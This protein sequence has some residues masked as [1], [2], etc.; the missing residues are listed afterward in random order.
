MTRRGLFLFAGATALAA[1]V[2][3]RAMGILAADASVSALPAAIELMGVQDKLRLIAMDAIWVEDLANALIHRAKELSTEVAGTPD[4]LTWLVKNIDPN[5]VWHGVN[6]YFHDFSVERMCGLL[7]S[8]ARSATFWDKPPP[9][10]AQLPGI[11]IDDFGISALSDLVDDVYVT[12]KIWDAFFEA[13]ATADIEESHMYDFATSLESSVNISLEVSGIDPS[14]DVDIRP[15]DD[16]GY[17]G[18][19]E[20]LS[21]LLRGLERNVS[22]REAF[23]QAMVE[24]DDLYQRLLS[25]HARAPIAE[26]TP[27]FQSRTIALKWSYT[28]SRYRDKWRTSVGTLRWL[29]HRFAPDASARAFAP[30]D[31][32][33]FLAATDGLSDEALKS[34]SSELLARLEPLFS[35]VPTIRLPSISSFLPNSLPASTEPDSRLESHASDTVSSEPF[36]LEHRPIVAMPDVSVDVG[37]E[38]SV[39]VR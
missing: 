24:S 12:P 15:A 27:E 17:A 8:L 31:M 36:L 39:E 29:L 37:E 35:E 38:A 33:A 13:L 22:L 11:F 1:S 3:G 16:R 9:G 20:F 18:A 2:P 25:I 14:R 32:R 7:E 21:H 28:M 19:S 30:D 34:P 23:I 10:S 5:I 4:G 6:G 26:F